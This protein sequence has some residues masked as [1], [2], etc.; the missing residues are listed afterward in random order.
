[1]P[2]TVG[3]AI[4][5]NAGAHGDDMADSVVDATVLEADRGLQTWTHADLSFAYR[6]S[7]LKARPDRRFIVLVATLAMQP[8][9]PAAVLAR[10]NAFQHYRRQTQPPGAS[11][12]SIFKNPPGTMPGA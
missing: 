8:D 11:L 6:H 5:N 2:G 10:M 7:A 3:G 12:G 9:D 4:V 1:M